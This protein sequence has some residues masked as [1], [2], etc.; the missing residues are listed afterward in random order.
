MVRLMFVSLFFLE[1]NVMVSAQK[2]TADEYVAKYKEAAIEEMHRSGVP[3]SIT[4]GQGLLET[5]NGNSELVQKSNNHF[6]IKCKSDWKGESVKHTD[7]AP[8]E[9]FRKYASARDSYADHSNYLKTSPRYA[10][11]FQLAPDDYKGW[12]RGLKRAG[13]ATN[14]RYT[15]ILIGNIE[16]YQ[17]NQYDKD[18]YDPSLVFSQGV[19]T[20][21]SNV[22]KK[23]T[24]QSQEEVEV[25][26]KAGAT[27][28]N[29]RYF[30]GLK[31]VF[32][33][34]NTSLLAIATNTNISLRRLMEYNDLKKDGL[35]A[36]PQYIYL[37]KKDKEGKKD[38]YI[39]TDKESLYDISQA[40]GIQLPA[41]ALYNNMAEDAI[42]APGTKIKLKPGI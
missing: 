33:K 42:V 17:L 7:D 37:E 34:A 5:E 39:S 12:A 41:L 20:D 11:L 38:Y 32:A 36:E 1:L 30:N 24:M 23:I 8:N 10:S 2:M 14:P 19:F 35:L 29:S 31:A 13:Y 9:C 6:G 18:I 25:P 22:A 3:A 26:E 4:L 40:N 21:S 27:K 15:D 16:R 28:D